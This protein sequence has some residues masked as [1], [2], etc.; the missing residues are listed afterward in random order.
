MCK[1]CVKTNPFHKSWVLAAAASSLA[2]PKR[3]PET[4]ENILVDVL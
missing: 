3:R 4:Y 2:S 1:F